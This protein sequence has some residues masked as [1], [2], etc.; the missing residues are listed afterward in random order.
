MSNIIRSTQS[1][2]AEFAYAG[3]SLQPIQELRFDVPRRIVG[4]DCISRN[5]AGLESIAKRVPKN[6]SQAV[7]SKF[8]SRQQRDG[9]VGSAQS[10]A[11]CLGT[12]D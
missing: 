12:D 7:T 6:E 5:S 11:R 10:R 3:Q 2:A 1:Y 8:V 4:I 9:V